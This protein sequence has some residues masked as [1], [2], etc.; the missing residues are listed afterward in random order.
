MQRIIYNKSVREG[1]EPVEYCRFVISRV[2]VTA[3]NPPKPKPPEEDRGEDEE[4]WEDVGEE[5][6]VEEEEE[7]SQNDKETKP[8]IEVG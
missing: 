8:K 6:I 7:E 3:L 5:D 1:V 2:A 4:E